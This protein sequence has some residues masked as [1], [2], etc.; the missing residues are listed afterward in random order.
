MRD[1]EE[2]KRWRIWYDEGML[3][4]EKIIKTYDG[5]PL[6]GGV[7]F[8]VRPK[9]GDWQYRDHLVFTDRIDRS[10]LELCFHVVDSLVFRSW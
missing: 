1:K 4:L 6:L 9:D 2:W 7:S 10:C 3:R 8:E 5:K